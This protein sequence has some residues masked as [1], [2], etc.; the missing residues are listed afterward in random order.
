MGSVI[1]A[2]GPPVFRREAAGRFEFPWAFALRKAS[3]VAPIRDHYEEGRAERDAAFL[4]C[5]FGPA[6]RERLAEAAKKL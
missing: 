4:E 3:R 6:A 2:T 5:R 1:D